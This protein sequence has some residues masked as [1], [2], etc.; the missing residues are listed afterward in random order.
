MR[1]HI[2]K[3]LS[4]QPALTDHMQYFPVR[5]DDGLWHGAQVIQN[6]TSRRQMTQRKFADHE[7]MCQN[8]AGIK[9]LHERWIVSAQMFDPHRRVGQNHLRDARRRRGAVSRG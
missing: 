8:L 4:E 9:K 2:S 3:T 5:G 7:G 1:I 6:D